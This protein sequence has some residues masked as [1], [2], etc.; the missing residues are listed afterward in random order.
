MFEDRVMLSGMVAEPPA[1]LHVAVQATPFQ[2]VIVPVASS[3]SAPGYAHT[4]LEKISGGAGA[5]PF[6]GPVLPASALTPAQVRHI[7]SLDQISDLGQ[8]Q[9]IAVVDAFDDPN[10]FSDADTFDQQVMTTLGGS[11]SYYTA[12]GAASSWLVKTSPSGVT[13]PGDRGWGQEISLDVEWMHAIAPLAKIYLV[14]AASNNFSDLLAADTFAVGTSVGATVVSN[15]WGGVEFSGETGYDSTFQVSGVTFVFSAG[16]NG[17]QSYPAESPYV[18]SV[19]GTTLGHDS[20]DNWTGETGW[21][22]GG[23]GVSAY[24]AKPSYQSGLSYSNRAGPDVAYDADPN[25]GFAVYDSY[26]HFGW[27]QYGGTSAGAPQ[28][29]ALISL[30][31]QGRAAA[32]EAPLDGLTQTLPAIY[33]M[34]TGTTGT[35]QLND[36]ISGSNS[37]GSAGPGYDLVT[38]QGTPRRSDLVDHAFVSFSSIGDPGFEQVQVGAGHFKYRPT[39]SAWTFTGGSGISANNSGFTSGNPPAPQGTQ[40]AFLQGTGS[41]SQSVAGWAA[42]T[43]V[44]T[45]DAAQRGNIQASRQDFEVLVDGT[46]ISTFTPSNTSYLSYSTVAFTVAAG[47]HTIAF[48]SLDSAG[49]D[50]TAFVDAVNISTS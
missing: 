12:Y 15:S 27:G 50:N 30:A 18:L 9:T 22:S 38:G 31:N 29:S 7:Y 42:G 20:N 13:P 17:D 44:I 43:Y 24:E 8:G 3:S 35:E 21:S 39:G 16:D 34:T 4:F 48:Q 10:I 46:V 32:N 36:V 14:E 2:G 40:V 11:T 23:G 5:K 33:S 26:G 41:I 19:G 37:V 6:G 28:W 45:F 1:D 25:T 47:S 49:G